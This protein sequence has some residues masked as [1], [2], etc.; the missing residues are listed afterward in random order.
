M[1]S[2]G[3][4]PQVR[5]TIDGAPISSA[6]AGA[7]ASVRVQQRLSL[8]SLCELT[9]SLRTSDIEGLPA[10]GGAI[11][12]R[13]ED[14]ALLFKGDVTAIEHAARTTTGRVMRVRAYDALH[15]LRKSQPVKSHAQ[16]TAVSLARELAGPLD[17]EVDAADEGQ[18]IARWVQH[19][20]SDLE[21][22]AEVCARAGMYFGVDGESLRIVTLDANEDDALELRLG[23][24]LFEG[25]IDRSSDSLCSRV[26]VR[27]WNPQRVTPHQANVD[28]DEEG[29]GVAV[30]RTLTDELLADDAEGESLARA[31]LARRDH[32]LVDVWGI[33]EGNA[34]LHAG[35]TVTITGVADEPCTIVVTSVDHTIERTTGFRTE[36][37]NPLPRIRTRDRA[38]V[39]ALG[40]VT[41]VDD[42]DHLGRVKLALP[43]YDDVETEWLPVVTAGAGAAKGFVAIPD[44]DDSVLA[45]FP[46]GEPGLGFVIGSLFRDA[47]PDPGIDGGRV[48]RF[49][50]LTPGG[51]KLQMDD[52]RGAIRIENKQGSFVEMLPDRMHL[53]AASDLVVE[54]PAKTI[55]IRGHFINFERG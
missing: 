12:L 31:E 48:K 5:L 13:V 47:H 9:F 16:F 6:A 23:D 7:L 53:H 20:Q 15:R 34:S 19:K 51:N 44:V 30:E 45:V 17:L 18:T 52:T 33:A 54:A 8:P 25:R 39:T 21:F 43:T 26:A 2:V 22:L 11:E 38:A 46:R 41:S 4:L 29:E 37:A 28:R 10:I 27:G 42:P 36:F 14:D 55:T 40:I 49:S 1:K 24:T 3:V 35:A 32:A 50:F